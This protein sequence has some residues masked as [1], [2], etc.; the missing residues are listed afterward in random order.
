MDAPES[1]RTAPVIPTYHDFVADKAA[2]KLASWT[3]FLSTCCRTHRQWLVAREAYLRNLDGGMV[4][5]EAA[6]HALVN[7]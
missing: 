7:G 1:K 2:S 3:Q 4:E 5:S 6:Y